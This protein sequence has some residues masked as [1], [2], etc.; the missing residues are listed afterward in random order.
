MS[1]HYKGA[2]GLECI[3]IIRGYDLDF[4]RGNIIKYVIR[5]GRKPG[6]ERKAALSKALHYTQLAQAETSQPSLSDIGAAWE[7]TPTE[8]AAIGLA[9]CGDM[10]AVR[11]IIVELMQD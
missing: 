2:G 8:L 7:L 11:S 4:C 10:G 5:A 3:H 1:E 9:I 6:E